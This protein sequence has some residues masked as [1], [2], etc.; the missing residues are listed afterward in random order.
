MNSS[1]GDRRLA[2]LGRELIKN[3]ILEQ[4]VI[5]SRFNSRNLVFPVLSRSLYKALP[6]KSR[7]LHKTTELVLIS[8][9]TRQLGS[10]GYFWPNQV[11]RAIPQSESPGGN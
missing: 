9:C 7:V 8:K 10:W 1:V 5:R 4:L 2:L 3:R 6:K 11:D